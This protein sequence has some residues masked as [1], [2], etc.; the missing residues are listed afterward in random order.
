MSKLKD[1]FCP[2]HLANPINNTNCK[3]CLAKELEA[4][5]D[6]RTNQSSNALKKQSTDVFI[7][8]SIQNLEDLNVFLANNLTWFRTA[9]VFDD[10][11]P[12]KPTSCRPFIV[13]AVHKMANALNKTIGKT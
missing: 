6:S 1:C 7:G 4:D 9:F 11:N 2:L 12:E 13:E 3:N 10:K 5:K 8:G